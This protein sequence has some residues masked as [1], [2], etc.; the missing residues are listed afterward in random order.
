MTPR[1]CT[2]VSAV[3]LCLIVN[4]RGSAQLPALSRPATPA[5]PTTAILGSVSDSSGRPLAGAAVTIRATS[6]ATLVTGTLTG[7]SGRFR[8]EGLAAG[9]YHVRI[10]Y[11]GHKTAERAVTLSPG[12]AI[13]NL[14]AVRLVTDV[15]EMS[16]VTAEALRSGVTVGIDRNIYSTKNMP[17]ATTGSATELLRNV[18]EL[19][20]DIEGNVKLQGSQS[21]ALHINGRPAPMRGEALRNF[22]QMMP[23][24]RIDRVEVV[25]NPSAKY[26]PEG[27]AGIVNIVLKDNIDL[28]LSGSFGL[29][30]DSRGR[31]GVNA[32]LNYQKGKLMLF[33]NTS[34]NRQANSMHLQDLRQNLLSTPNTFFSNDVR[35][36]ISG[37]FL[38]FDG[39]AE[40]KFDKVNTLYAGAR[41]H[42]AN[43]NLDGLQI[44]RILGSTRQPITW[45]N[46]NNANAVGFGNTDFSAGLRRIV[47]PQQHELTVEA[48][49]IL[50]TQRF[51][52]N[53][54]REFLS[55]TGQHTGT[56]DEQGLTRSRNQLDELSARVDYTRSLTSTIKIEAGYKGASRGTDY[57]N[58]LQRFTAGVGAPFKAESSDYNYDENYQQA[59]LLLSQQFGKLG[60]QAGAR[61]EVANTNFRLPAAGNFENRYNNLFPSLNLSYSKSPA[62]SARLSYSRRIDRPQPNM[63]NPGQPSADSL[64]RQLGNPFLKPK[65]THS[66]SADVT[67]MASWGMLKLSPYY[68][69]TLD[70]WDFFKTVNEQGIS[71]LTWLNTNSQTAY[72]T[73]ATLSLRAGTKANGFLS[74]NAYELKR[75]ASN[76]NA[77]YSGEGFR[78][79]ISANGMATIRPGTMI[80]GFARYQA[81][82]DM[83]QGRISSSVFSNIG[84]RHQLMQKKASLNIAVL[85]PFDQ[86]R[87]KFETKDAS[88]VQTSENKL[89]IRSVRIGVTYSF[90]RAP[91]PTAR[92]QPDDPQQA[93]DATQPQ[94][95]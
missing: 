31:H 11:I 45:S 36:D 42:S 48:R 27:I 16:A 93:P 46:W 25:P 19:D 56:P 40:Y 91:Q 15:I 61:G 90:G 8:V 21:V 37:H 51:E 5:G 74:F 41:V 85:D 82:Q 70:N 77:S 62:W 43:N 22:L 14:G 68:R 32:G 20:V 67:H 83:P 9:A 80:Q 55:P 18:P 30:A 66:V 12:S 73:N 1:S 84:L 94:I 87:F 7:Q 71:T 50:N 92:R 53:Y 76:L 47:K 59:Y 28:G 17:A 52:Q 58:K 89:S 29:T 81:P 35:N 86:F 69:K 65:Y 13:A 38:F 79:D 78:W 72:G 95:R 23:A 64:N 2:A 24:N 54:I 4:V 34:L 60:V 3:L 88:H 44:Y 63:M 57:A 10:G 26:D 39:S 75:D 33:G 49:F 6:D